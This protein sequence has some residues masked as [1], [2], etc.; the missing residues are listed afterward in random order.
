MER[1]IYVA[2]TG[3]KEL[4]QR[5]AIG[6]NNL[7]N[8]N[9]TGFRADQAVTRALPVFNLNQPTL[10]YAVTEGVTADFSQGPLQ[11]T[12]RELDVAVKGPGWLAVQAQDGQ[13]AYTRNGNLFISPTGVLQTADGHPVLGNNGLINLPP[14][15]S[16][17]IGADG[18]VSG[19]PQGQPA[20]ARVV[21]D[22]IKLVNPPEQSLQ[23]G[24]DG[25]FR[26]NNGPAPADARVSLAIGSLEASNVN[27][28]QAM[29]DMISMARQFETQIKI[30]QTAQQDSRQAAQILNLS[31]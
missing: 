5:Q 11:S 16:V 12:G 1:L 3:A 14:L 20:T 25:L 30:I 23:K 21:F 9:T 31:A 2:M 17:S 13:E 26:G 4:M 7:A 22:R 24:G 19:V 10:A 6:A 18:T 15:Q 27:P 29:V 28:V 8:V